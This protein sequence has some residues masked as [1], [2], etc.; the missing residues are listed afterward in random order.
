MVIE[1]SYYVPLKGKRKRKKE[2]EGKKEK[3]REGK[4]KEREG[5]E[6]DR[7]LGY[8]KEGTRKAEKEP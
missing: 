3:E 5:K 8:E 2:E 6:S 4:R 1:T 7:L